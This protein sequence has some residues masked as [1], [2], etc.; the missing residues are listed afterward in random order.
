[1]SDGLTLFDFSKK[2]NIGQWKII[3]DEVMGGLSTGIIQVNKNGNGVY[4]G[5][6]SLENNG[7]FSMV[8]Y[9]MDRMAVTD[10]SAFVIRI[11]GDGKKYQM[12]C[13][14]GDQQRHSYIYTFSSK[15]DWQ[16]LTIPFEKMEAFFRGNALKL[17]NFN[18][19]YLSQIAF[20]IGNN[21]EENF[22][23]EIDFIKLK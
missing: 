22:T 16:E 8:Q 3:N 12:R 13:K 7:G 6:V 17:P 21:K 23:L 14:S 18:G 15:K 1:M 11:K 19:D 9:N 5:H 2:S 20:L 10:Y 4:S